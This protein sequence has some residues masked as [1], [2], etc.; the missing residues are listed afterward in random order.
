M[1]FAEMKEKVFTKDTSPHGQLNTTSGQTSSA[2]RNILTLKRDK[3][4]FD[5]IMVI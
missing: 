2:L 4:R 1:R 3:M 5:E